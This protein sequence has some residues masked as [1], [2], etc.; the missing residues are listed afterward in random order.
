MTADKKLYPDVITDMLN[1]DI[2]TVN[3]IRPDS[4][5]DL[6]LDGSQIANVATTPASNSYTVGWTDL[7]TTIPQ[8]LKDV[9]NAKETSVYIAPAPLPVRSQRYILNVG[10][11]SSNA[12]NV[13]FANDNE[14]AV[15]NLTV[16]IGNLSMIRLVNLRTEALGIEYPF[17]SWL[18]V[19]N[20]HI[21]EQSGG[22]LTTFG[23]SSGNSHL[24]IESMSW[25]AIPTGKIF[26]FSYGGGTISINGNIPVPVNGSTKYVSFDQAGGKLFITGTWPGFT[27]DNIQNPERGT[28][29]IGGKQICPTF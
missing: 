22:Y 17:A 27:I 5:G 14:Q 1:N 6:M 19:S 10:T 24:A 3:G 29:I 11:V 26:A 13:I 8:I 12:V 18:S 4:E 9:V 21:A 7:T 28:V 15:R 25:D 16:S 2:K 20:L 23:M